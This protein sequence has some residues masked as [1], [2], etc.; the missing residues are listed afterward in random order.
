MQ[1]KLY[2]VVIFCAMFFAFFAS[3]AIVEIQSSTKMSSVGGFEMAGFLCVLMVFNIGCI[4]HVRLVFW[5][6]ISLLIMWYVVRCFQCFAS[7]LGRYP[8]CCAVWGVRCGKGCAE[9]MSAIVEDSSHV[10]LSKV[11]H[12]SDHWACKK[13]LWFSKILV[14]STLIRLAAVDNIL[15][16]YRLVDGQ[17]DTAQFAFILHKDGCILGFDWWDPWRAIQK[18]GYAGE[19]TQCTV[20][21]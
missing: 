8:P 14:S 11:S 13:L 20:F 15:S 2:F 19:C 21:V 18:A 6:R 1:S 16:W 12:A 10:Y 7:F 3:C 5:M 17:D 9:H 4:C